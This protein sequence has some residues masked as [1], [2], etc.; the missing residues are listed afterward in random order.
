MNGQKIGYIRVSSVEQNTERQL[1]EVSLDKIFE[2]KV[3]AKTANRPKLQLMLEHIREGD[4]V[5]CH[6][7]SRLARNIED[8]HRLVR[9]ITTKGCS[10]HFVKENLHFSG[11]QSDPTQELL[12]NML[13]A[14]YTFERQILRCRQAEGIAVAKL[15]GKYK[16]RPPKIDYQEI[17]RI[18]SQGFSISKTAEMLGVSKSS[19]QR[20]GQM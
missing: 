10:L 8:L 16:G 7:I 19:V 11:D 2:E 3:S 14:V 12:L 5:Y 18:R 4:E 1:S 9:E 17:H 13:G 20:A 15:K 6:D